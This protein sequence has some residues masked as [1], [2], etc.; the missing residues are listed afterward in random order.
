MGKQHMTHFRGG[1]H[2]LF[3]PTDVEREL[4]YDFYRGMQPTTV[5]FKG[6]EHDVKVESFMLVITD[7]V[8]VEGELITQT[9]RE[10]PLVCARTGE[11]SFL[12]R[13][14]GQRDTVGAMETTLKRHKKEFSVA[15]QNDALRNLKTKLGLRPR[16]PL[17]S[18]GFD[19][20]R[21][22]KPLPQIKVPRETEE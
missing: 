20:P 9:K 13:T 1:K 21:N 18:Y 14:F 17:P 22:R 16:K 4:Q 7:T 19:K 2:S 3:G 12:I 6:L 10:Y 11:V 15:I 8:L 5:E